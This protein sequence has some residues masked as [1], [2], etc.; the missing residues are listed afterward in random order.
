MDLKVYLRV[1][2]PQLPMIYP[3]TKTPVTFNSLIKMEWFKD[4]YVYKDLKK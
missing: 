4:F 3:Q 1:E 2:I